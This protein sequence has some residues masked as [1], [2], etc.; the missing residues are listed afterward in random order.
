M[1]LSI[2]VEEREVGPLHRLIFAEPF[3]QY[4]T[5]SPG[6]RFADSFIHLYSPKSWS[7]VSTASIYGECKWYELNS[8][9]RQTSSMR[10]EYFIPPP[11]SLSLW[12]KF[13]RWW[14]WSFLLRRTN[15]YSH[16][17]AGKLIVEGVDEAVKSKSRW[18]AGTLA[19]A[20]V[21][22]WNCRHVDA[23][24]RSKTHQETFP[25][26]K[27]KSLRQLGNSLCDCL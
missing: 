11:L 2:I 25:C 17:T 10:C 14:T 12:E 6:I 26:P 24:E 4:V 20:D 21:L 9:A 13:P 27:V 18:I 15:G 8:F 22:L 19:Q 7:T 3:L 5:I 16:A 1:L 23:D